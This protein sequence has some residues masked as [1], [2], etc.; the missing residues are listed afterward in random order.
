MFAEDG[1]VISVLSIAEVRRYAE[2]TNDSE[3]EGSSVL[4]LVAGIE[5]IHIHFNDLPK[6]VQERLRIETSKKTETTKSD[7]YLQLVAQTCVSYLWLVCCY[8]E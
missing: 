7:D 5:R 2:T 8:F 1:E 3:S 6:A 4:D